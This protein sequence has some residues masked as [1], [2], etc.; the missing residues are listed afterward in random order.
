MRGLWPLPAVLVA[1]T[2]A[3]PADVAAPMSE[4]TDPDER[5]QKR[6]QLLLDMTERGRQRGMRANRTAWCGDYE[7]HARTPG[8]CKAD[9]ADCLCE[10]HDPIGGP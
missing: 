8:G 7:R 5:R 10:C 4:P 1:A 2:P 9:P 6:V 3:P